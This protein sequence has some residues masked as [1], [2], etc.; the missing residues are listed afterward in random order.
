MGRPIDRFILV[1]YLGHDGTNLWVDA[2][3][4]LDRWGGGGAGSCT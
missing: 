4:G 2:F 1:T 3:Y